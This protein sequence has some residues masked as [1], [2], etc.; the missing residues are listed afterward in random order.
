MEQ[1]FID[2]FRQLDILDEGL[3]TD[4]SDLAF[5]YDYNEVQELYFDETKNNFVFL[6]GE[7]GLRKK[8]MLAR[9]CKD[10]LMRGVEKEDI[11]YLNY[12][13]PI[14]HNENIISLIADFYNARKESENAYLIINEIQECG[15]WFDLTIELRNNYPKIKL[16]CSSSTPPYIFEKIYDEGC[17]FCKIVVLS[18]KNASNIKYESD[19]KSV[20]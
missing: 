3:N 11:L 17:E 5:A 7:S 6:A 19:R 4:F 9:I 16:L 18:K 15:D 2:Y 8:D 10:L 13:L 14:L 1:K 12:E 20:V